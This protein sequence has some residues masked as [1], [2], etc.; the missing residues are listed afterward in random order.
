MQ[1]SK[2]SSL[3]SGDIAKL[4]IRTLQAMKYDSLESFVSSGLE[5]KLD[6]SSMFA[7]QNHSKDQREVSSYTDLL[8]FIDLLARCMGSIPVY[9]IESLKLNVYM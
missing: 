6:R 1:L 8:D 5:L 9:D 3:K 4:H 7:W 2:A